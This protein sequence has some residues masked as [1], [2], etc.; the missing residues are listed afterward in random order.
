MFKRFFSV[1]PQTLQ[2]V[3][4]KQP[5][6]VFSLFFKENRARINEENANL[7]NLDVMKLAGEAWRNLG[8]AEKKQYTEKWSVLNKDYLV[9]KEEYLK[10]LPPKRPA[11]S[12]GLYFKDISPSLRAENPEAKQSDLVKLASQKWKSLDENLKQKYKDL[13]D[14][15]FAEYK[16]LNAS[17]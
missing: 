12:F 14:T 7:A 11:T 10:S 16:K 13:Y 1:S 6:S 4:P 8:E 3:K 2:V 5:A 9:K 15:K 17:E